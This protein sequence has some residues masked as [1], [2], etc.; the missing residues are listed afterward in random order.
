MWNGEVFIVT[1]TDFSGGANVDVFTAAV[2][3]DG[4]VL[5]PR[6]QITE[7]DAWALFPSIAGGGGGAAVVWRDHRH[8]S[9]EI[10][11]RPIDGRGRPAGPEVR[12]T[13][14]IDDKFEPRICSNGEQLLVM[15][16]IQRVGSGGQLFDRD[17][18][19][20]SPPFIDE[21][22]VFPDCAWGD[23]TWGLTYASGSG[24]KFR[25]LDTAGN[26]LGESILVMPLAVYPEIAYDGA[27]F[28]IAARRG[29]YALSSELALDSV[30]CAQD[31]TPPSGPSLM[32]GAQ[33]RELTQL[34]WEP[35]DDEET[36]VEWQA[37]SRNT[38]RITI[39]DPA[40]TQWQDV[41]RPGLHAFSVS[42]LN[43]A[44]LESVDNTVV[45]VCDTCVA[46]SSFG[47]MAYSPG[48]QLPVTLD[49]LPPVNGGQY[50]VEDTPPPGWGA[51]NI[52]HGGG[53]VGGVVRWGPFA[54]HE[55]RQLSYSAQPPFV[56]GVVEFV[57]GAEFDGIGFRV[58]GA[59][60]I[61]ILAGDVDADGDVDSNDIDALVLDLVQV[62]PA[63]V[64]DVNQNGWVD[65]GD[66]VSELII[67]TDS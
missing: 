29:A 50:V 20:V 51:S 44:S 25:E 4:T 6:T 21:T 3:E 12:V 53:F 24:A 40:A 23:G 64:P 22:G 52:N 7:T 61:G 33:S 55:V 36:D 56:D 27:Q 48:V 41:P 67:L 16:H 17:G 39:L 2:A 46:R 15:Y 9:Q 60:S 10:Y 35:G 30:T 13:N 18:A 26:L 28:V 38:E 31:E 54:D 8:A 62:E 59:R 49:V 57:G 47:R 66:I 14:G 1:W 11:L 63:V 34:S 5:V 65:A 19:P 58:T 37:I 32:Q 42:S 45:H 43:Y